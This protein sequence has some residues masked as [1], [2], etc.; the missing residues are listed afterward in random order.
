MKKRQDIEEKLKSTSNEQ[1]AQLAY[2]AAMWYKT[3][4]LQALRFA[5]AM[6][7]HG[8]ED[9]FS[10]PWK[11]YNVLPSSAERFYFVIAADHALSN[12]RYLNIALKHRGDDRLSDLSEKLLGTG[13]FSDKIVQLRNANEHNTEYRLGIGTKQVQ[14]CTTISTEI[15]KLMTNAHWLVHI[16]KDMFI[17]D[18]NLMDMLNHL[19]EYRDEMITLLER[20][21]CEYIVGSPI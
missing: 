2:D 1:I 15:G 10:L 12:I 7:D 8:P 5:E 17:G 18:V 4:F 6:N 11:E 16:G 13:N 14:Y 3:T 20:I 21:H 19:H 9:P